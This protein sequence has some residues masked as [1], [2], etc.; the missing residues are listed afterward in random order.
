M[1]KINYSTAKTLLRQYRTDTI[2]LDIS[3]C[4]NSQ[5]DPTLETHEMIKHIKRCG[6]KSNSRN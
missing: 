1:Y 3:E 2:S 6:F 4:T 5:T